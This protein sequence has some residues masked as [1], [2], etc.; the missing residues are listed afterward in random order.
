VKLYQPPLTEERRKEFVK[1]AHAVAEST[2][3]SVRNIRR[4]AV[5][6]IKKLGKEN[7]SEDQIKD[8]E[9]DMQNITNKFIAQIDKH[10]EVKEREIMTV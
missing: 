7:I 8:A 6:Q 5:D 4:E 3:V 2:R 10:L 9:A 1:K